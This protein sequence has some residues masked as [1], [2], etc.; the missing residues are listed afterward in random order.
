MINW[1]LL[2]LF[3][4]YRYP[5]EWCNV[6]TSPD[7]CVPD[8]KFLD[9]APLGYCAPDQTIPSLNTLSEAT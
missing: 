2:G 3:W 6:I 4:G 5:Y 8:R 9:V 1:V 7:R